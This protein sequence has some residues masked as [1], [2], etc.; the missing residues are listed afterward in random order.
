MSALP[1]VIASWPRNAREEVRVQISEFQGN[2]TI[3]LR[4]WYSDAAGHLK[5]G[6]G[7]LTLGVRHLPDLADALRAARS[8]ACRLGFLTD[9]ESD[10][11]P[12]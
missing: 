4:N 3:D 11:A 10:N 5:P 2:V 12:R 8:E 9:G 1:I 7:G 6:K